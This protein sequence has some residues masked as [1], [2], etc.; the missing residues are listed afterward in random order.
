[1]HKSAIIFFCYI[2]LPFLLIPFVSVS[3]NKI[4]VDNTRCEY[5]RTPLCI[6]EMHPRF[7]WEISGKISRQSYFII[8]VA[9]SPALLKRGKA[10]MWDSG[11]VKSPKMEVVYA[12]K[13]LQPHTGYFYRIGVSCDGRNV[14]Y[15][16]ISTFA[17]AKLHATDWQAMW[18]TD[19]HDMHY[20]PAPLFRK[21]F[22]V[23][24]KVKQARLYVSGLGYYEMFLN[25]N[26]VGANY[27]DPGYTHFDKRVLYS[28]HDVGPLIA[29]GKNG[30]SVML[31][32]GWFNGQSVAVWNFHQAAWRKRPQLIAE[33]HIEF[34]GGQK[35]ILVTDDTWKTNTGA[36]IYNNI[37]S[38]DMIDARLEEKGWKLSS[39]N[40][41]HWKPA[42]KTEA[43]SPLLQ[44]QVMPA[45]QVT[46]E[47]K[48]VNI[49]AFSDSLYVF[50]FGQNF[51]GLCRL[52]VSGE[53]GTVITMKHGELLKENGRLEQGNINVYYKPKQ[54][55]EIFQTDVF[56]LRG[57]DVEEFLPSFS[58]H[59]FRYVEIHS[60]KSVKLTADNLTGRFM[61]TNLAQ[62]GSFS[63]SDLTL[64]KIREATIQS[65]KSNIHSIPTDCPQREKN[66]WTAD[67]HIIMDFA[68][69]NFD[70]ITFYEKWM[71]DFLDNQQADGSISGIVPSAGWGYGEWPGPVW[72]A[73]LFIVPEAIYNYH[74][75]SRCIE[76]IYPACEKYLS[77]LEKKEKNGKI[78]FGIGDWVFY[79]AKTSTEFTSMCYYYLDNVKM[80]KFSR[81]LG[82]DAALYVQKAASLRKIINEEYFNEQTSVYANG[83]QAAQAVALYLNIVPEG[84][85]QLVADQLANMIRENDHFLDFGLLGSKTVL[86]MLTRF[87]YADD[88][89]KMVVKDKAPS[90]GYWVNEKMYD[91]LPETWELSPK[92][93][94]A[95][96]NHVFLGDVSAWMVNDIAGINYNPDC[97]GYQD[98]IIKP[99]FITGINWAKAEYKSANG[100]ISSEWKRN[101]NFIELWVIIPA[102]CTATVYTHQKTIAG[103]GRHQ[104][105]IPQK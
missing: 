81:I 4:S 33:L 38:G 94:D 11:I 48:P 74:G 63:C 85:E 97:P 96:L 101:G 42:R 79:K 55:K 64:N 27:L 36:N 86:R 45:I 16:E 29:K 3:A 31:G 93:F 35:M 68:L 17:T 58:Y 75:D 100:L 66:G 80:A 40:D 60:S 57:D 30:L 59:G 20:E 28:T 10:D 71:N 23:N 9:T 82:K 22:E 19:E 24:R 5:T 69:L 15:S 43:P 8:Q 50:D 99:H 87:G 73:A 7:T 46:K 12:G 53:K 25:G 65:Y 49:K 76:R 89:Y 67:A 21:V 78:T 98:I 91:T 102:N 105:R 62:V 6:D 1:M 41:E 104:Y 77:Y 13:Q 56:I 18:I 26:R 39:F 2:V 103:Q 92:F 51:T 84:K 70:A 61:H 47:I 88:A 83:T 52:K 95:S 44:S 14:E 54:K 37:Y 90:W 72:D 34:V 32:N